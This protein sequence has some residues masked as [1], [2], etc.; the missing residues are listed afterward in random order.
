[1]DLHLDGKTVLVTGASG[2]IGRA[3][4]LAFAAEGARVV[5]HTHSKRAELD[6]WLAEQDWRDRAVAVTADIRDPASIAAAFEASGPVDICIANAGARPA[7]S[8]RLD[9]C[10]DDRVRETI[11]ANLLGSMWT[12]RAFLRNVAQHGVRGAS[13]TFIGSTAATFGE[14]GHADY[15]AAKA[16]LIG[17]M[18]SLKNEIVT[19]DPIGR[20]NL[21][22]PG[23][24]ATHVDRPALRN[25]DNVRKVVQTMPLRQLAR[26]E[27]IAQT[28]LWLSA[29]RHVTGQIITVAGGM[30]GR[31]LWE[32][33]DVDPEAI[34]AN[35][36]R[37]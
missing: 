18:R 8:E 34:R 28:A 13:L 27:D 2:G 3:L 15:A 11:D 16:G 7:A 37:E 29:A 14:A 10:A 12:A 20:V 25:L 31:L 26:A 24:T 6:A 23:W 17:L 21:L 1:M 22:E 5:C 36:Q 35:A 9:A 32:P 30:E 33:G 19:L 4:A